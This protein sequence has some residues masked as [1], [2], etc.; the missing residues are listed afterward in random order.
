VAPPSD[1]APVRDPG[2]T[3]LSRTYGLVL[4]VEAVVIAALYWL[5]RHFA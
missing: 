2:D 5:G 1:V 3:D 4:L